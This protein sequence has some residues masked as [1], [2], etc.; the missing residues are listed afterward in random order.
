MKV[1]LEKHITNEYTIEI[2]DEIMMENDD[3]DILEYAD[4]IVLENNLSPCSIRCDSMCLWDEDNNII[5]ED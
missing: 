2:P 3:I 1:T 5:A 4:N